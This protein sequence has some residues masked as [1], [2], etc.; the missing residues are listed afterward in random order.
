M[1]NRE[2]E[3]WPPPGDYINCLNGMVDIK[4][5][6][7]LSHDPKYGSR[8]Q[9]PVYYDWNCPFE[10]WLQF[11][12]EIFPDEMDPADNKKVLVRGQEKIDLLQQFFGYC[13]L[14]DC[15]FEKALF[16]KGDGANGKGTILHVLRAMVGRE[17]VCSLS[18]KDLGDPKFSLHFLQGKLVNVATETSH[19]DPLAT[20]MFKTI[21]S[22]E[23]IT[24]EKK[25]HDKFEF[26]PFAKMLLAMNE[27]PVIPD[28]SFGLE[29]R[30]LILE[31]NVRFDGAKADPDLKGKLEKEASGVFMWS[32]IGLEKLLENGGFT[33]GEAV[34]TANKRFVR[35]LHP[36]LQFLEEEC[37]LK[38]GVKIEVMEL[39][40]AYKRWCEKNS[41]R[42]LARNRFTDQLLTNPAIDKRKATH[43]RRWHF[44]GVDLDRDDS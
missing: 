39:Y 10:R 37:I 36:V 31:C 22:G 17:N 9:L 11:L 27:M 21:V 1:L 12:D 40:G 41:Y 23:P 44:I 38:E 24:T 25:F 5:G 33:M 42:A 29:R 19:R 16:L 4:S 43:N 6:K 3:E 35:N 15:R 32:L 30:L 14:C 28:R 34:T 8:T 26:I 7:L 20:E 2:E 18:M 13:L